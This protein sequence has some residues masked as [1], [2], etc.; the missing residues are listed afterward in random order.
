M[1]IKHRIDKLSQKPGILI[2]SDEY[3]GAGGMH[4]LRSTF[5]E[6]K[7]SVSSCSPYIL[8]TNNESLVLIHHERP[9]LEILQRADIILSVCASTN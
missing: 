6:D 2:S 7:M 5:K 9:D 4:R 1:F 3:V 8:S